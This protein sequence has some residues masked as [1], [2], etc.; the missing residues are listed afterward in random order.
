M[1]AC[2]KERLHLVH[3]GFI[4]I[5]MFSKDKRMEFSQCS[6]SP[7]KRGS[8]SRIGSTAIRTRRHDIT[9]RCQQSNNRCAEKPPWVQNHRK[10][11]KVK[12]KSQ[13]HRRQDKGMTYKRRHA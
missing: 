7:K 6:N 5:I 4:A 8:L 12:E 9:Q 3:S 2:T 13:E 11:G 1:S 10:G